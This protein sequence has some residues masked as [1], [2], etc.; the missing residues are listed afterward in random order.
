METFE[1]PRY[2]YV[3]NYLETDTLNEIYIKSYKLYVHCMIFLYI[4]KVIILYEYKR[5]TFV[6]LSDKIKHKYES[7]T[8]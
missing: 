6:S 2:A 1:S 5:Y 8:Q 3:Q 4:I 7:Y